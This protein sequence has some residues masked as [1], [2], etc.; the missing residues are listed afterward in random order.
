MNNPEVV[1]EQTP[2]GGD[3]S[4]M[5]YLD[6]DGNLAASIETAKQF[7]LLERKNS[8]EIVNEILGLME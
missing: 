8:G 4:E 2:N 1:K 6:K 5:Y 3:Y 7:R